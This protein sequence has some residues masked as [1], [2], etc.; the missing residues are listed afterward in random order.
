VC[1]SFFR[2]DSCGRTARSRYHVLILFLIVHILRF[3]SS[4]GAR[5]VCYLK[6][7]GRD[8]E[9][10]RE[11]EREARDP[12]GNKG[13]KGKQGIQRETRDPKETKGKYD[14]HGGLDAGAS[15]AADSHRASIVEG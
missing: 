1:Q 14:Y 12:K 2:A 13:S 6:G 7:T 4:K 3:F 8:R 9:R 5:F 10:N 15:R 11:R